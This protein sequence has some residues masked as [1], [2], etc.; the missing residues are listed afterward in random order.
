[1]FI[2]QNDGK[3]P[4]RRREKEFAALTDDETKR[5][6]EIYEEVFGDGSS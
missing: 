2:R 5:V 6:E 3:L 1:M 4:K